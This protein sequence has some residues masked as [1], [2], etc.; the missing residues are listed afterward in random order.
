MQDSAD[1]GLF[2]G[3]YAEVVDLSLKNIEFAEKIG[4]TSAAYYSRY[5]LAATHLYLED[6]DKCL[7]IIDD[8]KAY[9]I[10]TKDTIKM[11]RAY[12]VEGSVY[13]SRKEY[14]K[15]IPMLKKALP[16]LKGLKDTLQIAISYYNLSETSLLMD[17]ISAAQKY[18]DSTAAT[19]NS[20][21]NFIGLTTEFNLLEGRLKMAKNNPQGAIVNFEK[22]IAFSEAG[23]Y[24][25]DVFAETYQRYSEALYASGRTNDAYLTLK[26]YDS[27]KAEIYKKEKLK[28]INDAT[29]KY[30]TQKYKAEAERLKLENQLNEAKYKSNS[31]QNTILIISGIFLLILCGLLFLFYKRKK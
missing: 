14:S 26:K 15:A 23:E 4:D 12:N 16:L 5:V 2:A 7:E 6:Y 24:I 20:M 25:D 31:Q 10:K 11:A 30:D 22:A 1:F 28:M 3:K 17:N 21:D 9:G 19:I 18:F 13:T 29:A 27:I 8:Y